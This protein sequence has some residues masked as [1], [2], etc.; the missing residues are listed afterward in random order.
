MARPILS[1]A[2]L[3]LPALLVLVVAVRAEFSYVETFDQYGAKGLTADA[4]SFAVDGKL[5]SFIWA[6]DSAGLQLP[7]NSEYDGALMRKATTPSTGITSD[8]FYSFEYAAGERS[9]GIV[10]GVAFMNPGDML[11]RLRNGPNRVD[12]FSYCIRWAKVRKAGAANEVSFEWSIPSENIG[13][14]T[15]ETLEAAFGTLGDWSTRLDCDTITVDW[16]QSVFIHFRLAFNA[17]G[18]VT[19]SQFA[20]DDV[21]FSAS[22]PDMLDEN[23]S[24]APARP[25]LCNPFCDRVPNLNSDPRVNCC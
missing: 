7:F 10:P 6:P 12:T 5:H 4:G 23:P 11:F 15:L 17:A 21:A 24:D 9:M 19:Q 1:A 2:L 14:N 22:H 25:V 13:W 20:I 8:G 18:G 16:P 3:A